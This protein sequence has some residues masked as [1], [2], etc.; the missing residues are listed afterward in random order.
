MLVN[1]RMVKLLVSDQ[2]EVLVLTDSN[3][4]I[5]KAVTKVTMARTPVR[6]LNNFAAR[7]KQQHPLR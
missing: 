7:I 4:A 1:E 6:A 3:L 5:K 2:Y